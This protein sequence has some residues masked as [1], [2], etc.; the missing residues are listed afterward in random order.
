MTT[1]RVDGNLLVVDFDRE[2][3]DRVCQ[4]CG[5]TKPLSGFAL[6]PS[7][8]G[9]RRSVCRQCL[10]ERA[11]QARIAK[12]Q[13]EGKWTT[14]RERFLAKVQ[15]ALSGCHEWTATLR[16]DGYGSFWFQGRLQQAHRVAYVFAYG[17][18]PDGLEVHHTCC[19]PRC[20][21]PDHLEAVTPLE[22]W[23]QSRAPSRLHSLATRC[24]HGHPYDESNTLI[25]RGR[26]QCRACRREK[27]PEYKRR[28]LAKK[29]AQAS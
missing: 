23:R 16:G 19:N 4:Q 20:V 7:S 29:R 6:H 9:G 2:S 27:Q 21:N 13:L 26:R 5:Y 1:T 10:S 17:A 28:Y 14:D 8:P 24:P 11:K 3:T 22:N 25:L 12:R 15:I 18:V